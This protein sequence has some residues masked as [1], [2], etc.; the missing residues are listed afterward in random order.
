MA[1]ANCA[2]LLSIDIFITCCKYSK[3]PAQYS[4][5]ICFDR[6]LCDVTYMCHGGF[7]LEKDVAIFVTIIS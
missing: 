1:F 2:L 3:P 5:H 4:K 7:G 6:S